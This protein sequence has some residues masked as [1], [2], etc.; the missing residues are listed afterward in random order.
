[1]RLFEAK[2]EGL[3]DPLDPGFGFDLIRLGVTIREAVASAQGDFTH[4][5]E[6]GGTVELVERLSARFGAE[7]VGR[8]ISED[9]HRPES[10]SRLLPA[11]GESAKVETWPQPE[12]GEPPMRPLFLFEP[13]QPIEAVAE[14]PDGPPRQFTWRRVAHQVVLA[15]GPERIASEWWREETKPFTRDYYRLEDAAGR[16]FWVYREGLFGEEAA[17]PRWFLHGVFP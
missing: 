17:H 11:L 16:R 14:V 12:E 13:P 9:T 6:E 7:R 1:M 4:G 5:Q 15:E 3:I 8:F 10:A 2:L